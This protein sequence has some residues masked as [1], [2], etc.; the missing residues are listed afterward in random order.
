MLA[1]LLFSAVTLETWE[2]PGDRRDVSYFDNY[3][4]KGERRL[5]AG[6]PILAAFKGGVTRTCRFR[7]LRQFRFG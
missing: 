7:G 5:S 2:K 6:C 3:V 1:R 4:L